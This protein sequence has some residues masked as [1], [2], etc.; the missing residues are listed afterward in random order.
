M[1]RTTTLRIVSILL[2]APLTGLF[3]DLITWRNFVF[4]LGFSHYAMALYYSK[5]HA[6]RVLGQPSS[7]LPLAIV[8]IFGGLLY[9]RDFSLVIY[10]AAHHVF[11]ESYLPKY[12][13]RVET[14]SAMSRLR[15]S[16]LFLN[17]FIYLV[18]L[19]D[20]RELQFLDPAVL[21]SGL[22][23]SIVSFIYFLRAVRASMTRHE[24][25]DASFFELIGILLVALSFIVEITFL[26]IVCYH[27]VF[28]IFY[29]MERIRARGNG[30]I[31]RYLSWT[32]GLTA[33][34]IL[35]SPIGVLQHSLFAQFF[36][37]QFM[38]WSYIHI[39]I[40]YALSPIHPEWIT[41]WFKPQQTIQSSAL[42]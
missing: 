3:P 37:P 25:I 39:T 24:L 6:A 20:H 18:I 17:L 41:R 10:F 14:H 34:F 19:Q 16:S 31:A 38:M 32:V 28:W 33:F 26:Q 15:N 29:P 13:S 30:E 5:H 21:Y 27:F 4:S 9:W 36:R 22:A 11:N 40:S 12:S 7:Y 1:P 8:L 42:P 23:L 35:L 2:V